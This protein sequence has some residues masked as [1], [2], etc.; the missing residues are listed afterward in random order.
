M[1]P[2]SL[3]SLLWRPPQHLWVLSGLLLAFA[4]AL[5]Q[6]AAPP[7]VTDA[8]GPPAEVIYLSERAITESSGLA[9]SNRA[10][11]IF[12]THNDSGDTARLFAFD[13]QGN[14]VGQ[15]VLPDVVAVDWEDLVSF[16]QDGVPRLLVADVGD[17]R[18]RRSSVSLYLF[19]E[20]DPH[21]ASEVTHWSRI[22]LRYPGGPRDCEAVAVDAQAG[23]VTL[24]SKTL[25]PRASVYEIDLPPRHSGAAPKQQQQP[26]PQT[27][28]W[29]GHLPLALVT[30]M[31]RDEVS[32]DLVLVNYFQLFRF[33]GSHG[34][35][36]WWQQTPRATDLP[37][38]KQIEAVAIDAEQ[39]VWVTSE[40]SPA[41]LAQVREKVIHEK[42]IHEQ[43]TP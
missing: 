5:A 24:V 30:A 9:K 34:D 28:R 40:G 14:A 19:D 27:A 41:P 13:E 35:Q 23:T 39:R 21:A 8:A 36:K 33:P 4:I 2:T 15:C 26:P 20:P 37:K 10:A 16:V 22:D 12:W 31:D 1:R 38:L 17:N 42:T 18:R 11:G 43:K 25:L 7:A 6:L 32:G 29:L 3:A